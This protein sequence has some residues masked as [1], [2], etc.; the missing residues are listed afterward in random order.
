MQRISALGPFL[1]GL[2]GLFVLAPQD[3]EAQK[4]GIAPKKKE[5]PRYVRLVHEDGEPSAMQT[6]I[7]RFVPASGD[8]DLVVDLIGVVHFGDAAYYRS[9]NRR[10]QRYDAL[11]YEL[12]APA[13]RN[14]PPRGGGR[15]DNPFAI[16]QKMGQAMFGLESQLAHIDY[17]K[18]NFVHA[19]LSPSQMLQ[20]MRARGEDGVTVALGVVADLMRQYNLEEL[21]RKSG[22]TQARRLAAEI[23]PFAELMR[24]GSTTRLKRAFAEELVRRTSPDGGL[25]RTLSTILVDDR[26]K[27]AMRVFQKELAKGKKRIGI[28][29][30]AAHM[31][32]FE[33]RLVVDFGMKKAGV[34][35]R[36]AWD[37]RP[38]NSSPLGEMLKMLGNELARDLMRASRPQPR[39]PEKTQPKKTQPKKKRRRI[40]L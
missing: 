10:F 19:D 14:V 32:D 25:G 33:R 12:I 6:A 11:L 38:T 39:P 35:W 5:P 21:R 1:V 2:F 40:L 29:F 22:K 23:D 24:P 30:G 4:R 7:A 8:G 9:L 37:L 36:T 16:L 3:V 17:T 26:N 27:A 31:P 34:E 13:T 28:F 18:K 15:S 20:A